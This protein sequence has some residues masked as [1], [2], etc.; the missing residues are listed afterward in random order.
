MSIAEMPAG[1]KSVADKYNRLSSVYDLME[2]PM[3]FLFFSRWR[4]EVL[5]GLGGRVLEVGVGTGKNLKYYPPGCLI[6]G[7]DNSEGM[8]KKARKKAEGMNNVTLLL[9]DA[10]HL[11]FPDNTFDY[12]V[13]TFVLCSIPDP[14]KALKEM[15]RVLKPSG[16]MI[17][18]EHMRSSNRFISRFEDLINPIIVSMTGIHVNRKTVENVVKAGFAIKDVEN[19]LLKDV[20][21]KIRSKP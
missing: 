13:T 12:V 19:L 14:V 18:L 21:R 8:L 16:E 5:S 9:M 20:F 4:K 6:I 3:E 1:G 15:R 2:W 17:N 7:I 11:E 10:E